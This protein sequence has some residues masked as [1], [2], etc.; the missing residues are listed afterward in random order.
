MRLTC[1]ILHACFNKP[2]VCGTFGTFKKGKNTML[3]Y[4]AGHFRTVHTVSDVCTSIQTV[5]MILTAQS[6]TAHT[7]MPAKEVCL[8]SKVCYQI[9]IIITK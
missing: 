9:C 3:L 7:H 8:Y 6:L 2:P 5:C 1:L 4:V